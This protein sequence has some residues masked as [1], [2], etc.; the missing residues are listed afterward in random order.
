[1]RSNRK[2]LADTKNI[3]ENWR[4]I[5]KITRAYWN[6]VVEE[7]KHKTDVK[8]PFIF[9]SIGPEKSPTEIVDL[10]VHIG[11]PIKMK[12]RKRFYF[13]DC[14]GIP[15]YF[16]RREY[17]CLGHLL[18][19]KTIRQTAK[20]LSISYRTAEYFVVNMR[21]KLMCPTKSALLLAFKKCVPNNSNS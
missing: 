12:K 1:M 6:Q 16:T 14:R 8:K 17:E 7:V 5:A 18:Q 11:P 3:L 20:E 4:S 19:E 2:T 15:I 13:T 21:K 9:T 10:L